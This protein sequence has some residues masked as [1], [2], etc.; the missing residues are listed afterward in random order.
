MSK[1]LYEKVGPLF[2]V[3]YNKL[4]ENTENDIYHYR[5]FY[6]VLCFLSKYKTA[7]FG[8]YELYYLNEIARRTF[9]V[10]SHEELSK[11]CDSFRFKA[12]TKES[13]GDPL[14]DKTK[15]LEFCNQ[16][17][18]MKRALARKEGEGKL[19]PNMLVAKETRDISHIIKLI[20]KTF[21]KITDWKEI[22]LSSNKAC[23]LN[24]STMGG[25]AADR[26]SVV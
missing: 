16:V 21:P 23:I 4:L 26:K 15:N 7:F 11:L 14:V 3:N 24:A 5:I 10:D 1:E 22:K 20:P 6:K 2:L 13:T 19:E 18:V 25:S 17:A 9:F 12:V 8:S